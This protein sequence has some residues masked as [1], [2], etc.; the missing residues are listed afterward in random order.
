MQEKLSLQKDDTTTYVSWTANIIARVLLFSYLMII[1]YPH[2]LYRAVNQIIT[3]WKTHGGIPSKMFAAYNPNKGYK[4][5][6]FY[7]AQVVFTKRFKQ[8]NPRVTF[9][10]YA[11]YDSSFSSCPD[12][13]RITGSP[14]LLDSNV[15]SWICVT[16]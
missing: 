7:S 15:T 6:A 1:H 10:P 5:G 2:T 11:C 13:V 16:R 8:P 3:E 14:I 4:A 9:I 12:T